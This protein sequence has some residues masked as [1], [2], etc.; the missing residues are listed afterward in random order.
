MALTAYYHERVPFPGYLS[1]SFQIPGGLTERGHPFRLCVDGPNQMDQL[2]IGTAGDHQIDPGLRWIVLNRSPVLEVKPLNIVLGQLSD[3]LRCRRQEVEGSLIKGVLG[4]DNGSGSF[5]PFFFPQRG[6]FL[7]RKSTPSV[8]PSASPTK[9]RPPGST[10]LF[11]TALGGGGGSRN[12]SFFR[13][14]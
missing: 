9:I 2:S 14:P 12:T 4:Q 6:G 13:S 1:R 3:S 11:V 10:T 5:L 8:S 7:S